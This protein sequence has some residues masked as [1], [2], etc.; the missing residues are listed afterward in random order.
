MLASTHG[1]SANEFFGFACP[2]V[3]LATE[4]QPEATAA[5]IALPPAL[6]YAPAY[7]LPT[8]EDAVRAQQAQVSASVPVRPS[9]HG[10]ARADGI[11]QSTKAAGGQKV[12]RIL[13]KD[14]DSRDKLAAGGQ[15]S[16][17]DEPP[18]TEREENRRE[19]EVN[20]LRYLAL[21]SAYAQ[22]PFA[23]LEVR[24][25]HIHNWGLFCKSSFEKDAMIVEYI[26]QKIRQAVADRREAKYEE[27]GV[28]SCYLFRLDGQDIVDATRAGGMAR[29]INHCCEPNAYAKIVMS[30]EEGRSKHIVIMAT[31]HIQV[32]FSSCISLSPTTCPPSLSLRC[33][34]F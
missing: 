19:L 14:V 9:V 1:L 29:F 12:R 21:S 18:E 13:A 24:R 8:A 16:A 28:G 11:E 17:A 2:V 20:R 15:R 30:D 7:V 33:S 26:G 4:M 23:R 22:D 3:R 32:S 5:V 25:S 34:V 6:Q 10:C 31:R 27:E